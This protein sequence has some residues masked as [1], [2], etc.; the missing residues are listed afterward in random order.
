MTVTSETHAQFKA[1]ND[2]GIGMQ[3]DD[4]A[5]NEC[6]KSECILAEEKRT[7]EEGDESSEWAGLQNAELGK[8]RCSTD[9]Q[10]R[11]S[12]NHSLKGCQRVT[13]HRFLV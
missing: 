6:V 12:A 8:K 7:W 1:K 10:K 4:V 9:F 13:S 11:S 3:D 2:E 5:L